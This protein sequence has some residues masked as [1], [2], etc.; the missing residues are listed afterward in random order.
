VQFPRTVASLAGDS[1]RYRLEGAV[2]MGYRGRIG[3]VTGHTPVGKSPVKPLVVHL[4]VGTEIPCIALGVPCQRQF[5]VE[6]VLYGDV[7]MSD[8]SA[9]NDPHHFPCQAMRLG[10][11]GAEPEFLLVIFVPIL[12]GLIAE[13]RRLVIQDWA[14]EPDTDLVPG[15]QLHRACHPVILIRCVLLFMT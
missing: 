6:F 12:E 10:P 8:R 5:P 2:D 14:W 7:G 11:V 9:S 1:F 3:V 4:V 15:K 13:I